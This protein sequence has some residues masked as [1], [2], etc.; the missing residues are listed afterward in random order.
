[1]SKK[2]LKVPSPCVDNYIEYSCKRT[3][4]GSCSVCKRTPKELTNWDAKPN[5][6][7]L[8]IW[9]SILI[10]GFAHLDKF[11]FKNFPKA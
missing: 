10:R 9:Q 3:S 4:D 11:D 2:L 5:K 7:R 8:E 6:D 1:M